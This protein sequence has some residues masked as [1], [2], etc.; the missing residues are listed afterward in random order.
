MDN[1]NDIKNQSENKDNS[2]EI[3]NLI[4][5]IQS[6]LDTNNKNEDNENKQVE[7]EE[8]KKYTKEKNID[9]NSNLS[10]INS[11]LQNVDL[12]SIIHLLG[13][14]SKEK[15]NNSNNS[16]FNF[17]S[18]DPNTILRIKKIMNTIG[19]DDPQKNLLLSLKPFLR[20][21]RQDKIGEY[22]SMLT[23]AKA[24]EIF[25]SKGSDDNVWK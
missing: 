7:F 18:I 4:Q 10:N 11:I 23:I 5:S 1:N 12:N 3:F 2:Q 13:N 19:K 6:K 16:G 25:T 21:S 20:K 9:N 8:T 22:M 24:I 17:D 14:S 15:E